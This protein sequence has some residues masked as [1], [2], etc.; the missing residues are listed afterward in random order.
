MKREA[1]AE[2]D[3]CQGRSHGDCSDRCRYFFATTQQEFRGRA[4]GKRLSRGWQGA[5]FHGLEETYD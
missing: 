5:E 4:R 2:C 1:I 3:R